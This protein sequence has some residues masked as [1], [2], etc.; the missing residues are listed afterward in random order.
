MELDSLKNIPKL[1]MLL[2]PLSP[3]SILNNS[4]LPSPLQQ[5]TFPPSPSLHSPLVQ[6][7]HD[8]EWGKENSV[9]QTDEE[10]DVVEMTAFSSSADSDEGIESEEGEN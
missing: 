5:P 2:T 8:Q 3:V 10:E 9:V 4:P 6:E 7:E 1:H